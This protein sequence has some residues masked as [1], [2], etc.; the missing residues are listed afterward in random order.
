M[1]HFV[2][3]GCGAADL[4]TVRGMR[5]LEEA[6]CVIYAGSLVS[7]ELLHYCKE[8]TEIYDSS[9]MTLD[10]V[11]EIVIARCSKNRSIVRLHTGDPSLYGA[12]GEQIAILQKEGIAYD[13]TPGVTAAFGAAAAIGQEL[14]LPELTQTIIFTRAEGRTP[15]PDGES[16]RELASHKAS[17]AIYLSATRV[18]ELQKQLLEGG[19][20][21]DTPVA[22][23]YKVS[24]PEEKILMST[25]SHMVRDTYEN[26]LSLTT[27]YLV[28][29]TLNAEDFQRSRLYAADFSTCYRE[30]KS[31]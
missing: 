8:G 20:E 10:E 31:L 2:G 12:I 19:Y 24:W 17:M 30:A 23:C 9:T 5:M 13:V 7:K 11:M 14:T 22:I 29:H 4:I 3:A 15:M 28:S 21:E 1:V 6:D 27:L 26:K 18:E 16:I 25:I